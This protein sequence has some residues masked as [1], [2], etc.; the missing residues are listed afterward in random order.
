VQEEIE[1][2]AAFSPHDLAVDGND[3]M[4]ELGIGPGP[5]VGRV[6]AALFERVL[7]DP[8]LNTPDRLLPLVR[9]IGAT[10]G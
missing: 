6:I 8:G 4:R 2:S 5:T 10:T 7:D 3:V 1:R 9:E